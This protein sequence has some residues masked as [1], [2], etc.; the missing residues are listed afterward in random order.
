MFATG[1]VGE[2]QRKEDELQTEASQ[3]LEPITEGNSAETPELG[4][5][6]K[7]EGGRSRASGGESKFENREWER[8]Q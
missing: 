2:R 1:R 5:E 8:G 4:E 7:F 6:G 3:G